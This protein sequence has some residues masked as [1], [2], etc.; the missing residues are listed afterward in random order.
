MLAR[1]ESSKILTVPGSVQRGLI[2][3]ESPQPPRLEN[4][5]TQ[6][7]ELLSTNPGNIFHLVKPKIDH[8]KAMD[9]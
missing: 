5:L 9:F 4:K 7:G 1:S 3:N 8:N 6:F 2:K